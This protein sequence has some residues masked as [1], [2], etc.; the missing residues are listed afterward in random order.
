[1][2]ELEDIRGLDRVKKVQ[3]VTVRSKQ[4]EEVKVYVELL[5]DR[6]GSK[7]QMNTF[8]LEIN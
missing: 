2:L 1:M 6:F 7:S 5:I 4:G 3:S 8:L